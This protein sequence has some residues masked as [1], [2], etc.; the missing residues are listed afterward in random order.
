[1]NKLFLLPLW[2]L[3]A[4]TGYRI[5]V[6]EFKYFDTEEEEYIDSQFLMIY[7]SGQIHITL[8]RDW[9]NGI[10]TREIKSVK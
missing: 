1:M 9:T 10:E 4:L 2:A 5:E 8:T 6:P 3:F 7:H